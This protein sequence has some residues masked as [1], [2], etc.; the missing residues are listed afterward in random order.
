MFLGRFSTD[1]GRFS[2]KSVPANDARNDPF[3]GVLG[4]F[5]GID[6]VEN[7]PKAVEN[8]PENTPAHL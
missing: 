1:F 8:R 4:C 6:L 7:R 2:A 3:G 5:A